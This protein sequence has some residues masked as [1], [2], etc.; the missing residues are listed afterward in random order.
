MTQQGG[1]TSHTRMAELAAWLDQFVMFMACGLTAAEF[2]AE[3]D[4]VSYWTG[5]KARVWIA[6]N[7]LGFA[8]RREGAKEL[9]VY[10]PHDLR[11]AARFTEAAWTELAEDAAREARGN[12]ESGLATTIKTL[13]PIDLDD[14]RFRASRAIRRGRR[15]VCVPGSTLHNIALTYELVRDAS[16]YV[17][18]QPKE[19]ATQKPD[20]KGVQPCRPSTA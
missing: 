12:G 18:E 9:C 11:D 8:V 4:K 3:A 5:T 16:G 10:E 7:T 6:I 17:E 2:F 1:N 13:L 20:C 15:A 14:C 19:K